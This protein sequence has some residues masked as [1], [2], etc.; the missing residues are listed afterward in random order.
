MHTET[1]EKR[2][3][4]NGIFSFIF[5]R[6]PLQNSLLLNFLPLKHFRKQI[7]FEIRRIVFI[8]PFLFGN[9]YREHKFLLEWKVRI[10]LLEKKKNDHEI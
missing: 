8:V 4:F 2:L 6:T 10:K 1:P 5:P 9:P 3:R 7:I